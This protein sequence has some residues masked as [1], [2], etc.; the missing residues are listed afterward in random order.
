MLVSSFDHSGQREEEQRPSR[1][2][3]HLTAPH[4]W[5][6]RWGQGRGPTSE[7]CAAG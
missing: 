1:P 4:V 2:L 5:V 3:G 7:A 6:R